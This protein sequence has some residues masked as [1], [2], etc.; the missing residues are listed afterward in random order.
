MN[1]ENTIKFGSQ[2][3]KNSLINSH[4]L[5][6]EILLS[7]IMGVSRE[8][9]LLNH[10]IEISEEIKLK[11]N[12][13]INRR[14][15]KEPVAYITG[16]KEFWSRDFLVNKDTLIPRP[17][18][19]LLIY[20]VLNF[21]KNRNINILDI[22]TGSGCILLSL[23]KELDMARGIG[24]DI[25]SKAI[26]IAKLN[27]KN[28]N[29]VQRSKFKVFDVKRFNEGRYDLIISNPPYISS[30]DIKNLSKDIINNEPKKALDGG[31]DGLDLIREVIY[32]SSKLLKKNGIFSLEIGYGQYQKVSSILKR[33]G[34]RE[35]NKEYDCNQNVR[36]I[37]STK[38]KFL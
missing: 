12:N 18:T 34:Y 16:K 9:L 15:K 20:K 1:L 29:L 21:F 31:L 11:Y 30:K 38:A 8:F 35:I 7:D 17:E 26:K 14:L 28:L 23:L 33:H 32:K 5:D 37:M 4:E 10:N 19:E 27:S 24:I 22:G 2:L 25:C 3:L 13:S 36:C 6:A